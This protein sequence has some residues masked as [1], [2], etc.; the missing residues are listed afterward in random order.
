MIQR[1]AEDEKGNVLIDTTYTEENGVRVTFQK[2]VLG[3]G[4]TRLPIPGVRIQ[5]QCPNCKKDYDV[6]LGE[7]PTSFPNVNAPFDFEAYCHNCSHEFTV[8]ILIEL[9][10]R[11]A[12]AKDFKDAKAMQEREALLRHR[13]D[14]ECF[15]RP[16]QDQK[17]D[18][19]SK[20]S[21]AEEFDL[22]DDDEDEEAPF[23]SDDDDEDEEED[24]EDQDEDDE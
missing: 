2:K 11:L 22:D 16:C 17:L 24:E 3:I 12:C 6:D 8:P 21:A 23:S 10:V 20:F 4:M 5:T 15:C 9:T 7:Y 19:E 18:S 1:Y 14:G 13:E